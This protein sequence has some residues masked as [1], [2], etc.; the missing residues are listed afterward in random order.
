MTFDLYREETRA[1]DMISAFLRDL[2]VP[3][4]R[5]VY[6]HHSQVSYINMH[7]ATPD[8]WYPRDVVSGRGA[9]V[10]KTVANNPIE[11]SERAHSG[12]YLDV[13]CWVFTPSSFLL[14]M[15][16]IAKEGLLKFRCRQF[17][18]SNE[19]G[20]DR[21]NHSFVVVLEKT[22]ASADEIRRSFLEPLG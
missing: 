20:N 10:A 17:Y 22:D 5:A 7:W 11:L 8:S 19:A 15:A 3:D 18:P 2:T 4:A 6:D 13:H 16:Q 9:V 21:I 14:T 1:S 12:D